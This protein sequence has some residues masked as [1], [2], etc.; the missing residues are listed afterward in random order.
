MLVLFSEG[1]NGMVGDLSTTVYN[2]YQVTGMLEDIYIK[3]PLI[4][5]E[6][7]VESITESLLGR[8][9]VES[10]G[11]IFKEVLKYL[12]SKDL[13]SMRQVCSNFYN[14]MLQKYPE[15]FIVTEKSVKLRNGFHQSP[16]TTYPSLHITPYQFTVE[17]VNYFYPNCDF[18][19]GLFNEIREIAEYFKES[20]HEDVVTMDPRRVIYLTVRSLFHEFVNFTKDT[21]V[22]HDDFERLNLLQWWYLLRPRYIEAKN[23]WALPRGGFLALW[24]YNHNGQNFLGAVKTPYSLDDV[25]LFRPTQLKALT[26]VVW[27]NILTCCDWSTIVLSKQDTHVDRYHH[28]A[29]HNSKWWYYTGPDMYDRRDEGVRD[30]FSHDFFKMLADFEADELS[31]IGFLIPFYS[32]IFGTFYQNGV[33]DE[34]AYKELVTRIEGYEEAK[35]AQAASLSTLGHVDLVKKAIVEHIGEDFRGFQTFEAFL[36]SYVFSF[37]LRNQAFLE[38]PDEEVRWYESLPFFPQSQLAYGMSEIMWEGIDIV[39]TVTAVVKTFHNMRDEFRLN[40]QNHCSFVPNFFKFYEMKNP[41]G[42][43]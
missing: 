34:H 9:I 6:R 27:Y 24:K 43:N 38:H 13:V 35:R 14:G 33:Y 5:E 26:D 21:I 41:L 11:L 15:F 7:G 19:I 20:W 39:E 1:N 42:A 10:D 36:R 18:F 31:A 2:P 25:R 3:K 4:I 17:D 29:P 30:Y 40:V 8:L 22:S 28:Y 12:P 32:F 23:P 37:N 16:F